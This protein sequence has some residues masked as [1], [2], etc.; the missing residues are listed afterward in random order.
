MADKYEVIS[1]TPDKLDDVKDKH[2]FSHFTIGRGKAVYH[3]IHL[4][5]RSCG[6]YYALRVNQQW[7]EGRRAMEPNTIIHCHVKK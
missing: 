5:D 3:I 1:I 2:D 4:P 7:L 6:I